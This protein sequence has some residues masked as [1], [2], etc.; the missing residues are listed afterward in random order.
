MTE[1]EWHPIRIVENEDGN[2]EWEG[3][4]PE[5]FVPVLVTS[6]DGEIGIDE[7]IDEWDEYHFDNLICDVIAWA[8]LPE[9]YKGK[10]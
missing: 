8:E 3:H 2:V 1:V 10:Q 7:L 4:M 6:S 5:P 9:P